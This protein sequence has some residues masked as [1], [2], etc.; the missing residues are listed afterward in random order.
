[1]RI[2]CRYYHRCTGSPWHNISIGLAVAPI[3][4]SPYKLE[5]GDGR[6]FPTIKLADF[7]LMK[8]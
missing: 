5:S 8:R 3:N 7:E 6:D 2:L 4:D 1:M